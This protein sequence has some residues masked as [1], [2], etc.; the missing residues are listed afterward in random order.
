M[1]RVLFLNP[2]HA[3]YL[4]DGVFHGLRM[5]LGADAVDYPKA[6]YL[7]ATASESVRGRLWGRGFTLY[8]LL[9]DQEI[10]RSYIL[11]RALDGE[12][13]LVVFGD[14]WHNF[15]LW[16][17]WGP[18]LQRAGVPMAVLD[19]E[20]RTAPYPYHWQWWRRPS[21]WFLPRAHTRAAVFKREITPRT[22]WF[23]SYLLLPP[24]LGRTLG[25]RSIGFSIPAEKIVDH[26]PS[27]E[28]D[29]PRHIVDPELAQRLGADT[30]HAFTAESDYY[31]D[32]QRARFGITT[33]R[34][35]W[36]ALRHYE[37]AANAAVPCF[38]NLDRKPPLCAP[39]GLDATNCLIYRDADDLLAQVAAVDEERYSALQ[40]GA[41]KWARANTT[42]AR[43]TE[44]L[45]A[46][47]ISHEGG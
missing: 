10:D 33:K 12:F 7:Y 26:L 36:E 22:R 3:D 46:C 14:I 35:G 30:G 38:R 21:W 41:L 1:T 43:A 27:K 5:L 20:D 44:L 25:M 42:L 31:S 13:D 18:Q 16:T 6:D 4:P 11:P 39:F 2:N 32:L 24:V 29:F 17:E 8:G 45:T 9:D 37:I 40:S 28:T 47:G 23:A 34:A 15:G 19:G